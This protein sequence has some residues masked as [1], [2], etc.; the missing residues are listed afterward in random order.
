MSEIIINIIILIVS[1]YV[2]VKQSFLYVK[3]YAIESLRN[4]E[5]TIIMFKYENP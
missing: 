3:Y 1:K 5:K 4:N 2:T